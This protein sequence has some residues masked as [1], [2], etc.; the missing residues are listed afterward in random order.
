MRLLTAAAV[1]LVLGL[2]GGGT[3]GPNGSCPLSV[4]LTSY[5]I[6][7]STLEELKESMHTKGPADRA[8]TQRYALAQW[9]VAWS[10]QRTP[11]G[12]IDPDTVVLRCDGSLLLPELDPAAGLGALERGRWDDYRARLERHER[13]HLR[14]VERMAPEIR[15]RIREQ[16]RR[17][18]A[19]PPEAGDS[20]AKRVLQEIRELDRAYGTSTSHGKSEGI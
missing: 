16:H 2:A 13:N 10:W 8:G 5:R 12:M 19:V 9:N 18:G 3:V 17:T 14:H 15:R 11:S 20:I 6:S 7:G 1:C 4:T